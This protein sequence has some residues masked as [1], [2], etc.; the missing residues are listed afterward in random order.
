[1]RGAHLNA[2]TS[3]SGV[4]KPIATLGSGSATWGQTP[5]GGARPPISR[6]AGDTDAA[7]R[8][9]ERVAAS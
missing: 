6:V 4:S 7:R 9:V 5:P 2:P 3:T 8:L 1:M